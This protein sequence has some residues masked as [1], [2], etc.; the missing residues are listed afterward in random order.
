MNIVIGVTGSIAAYKTV[1]LVNLLHKQGHCVRVV[2][3][4]NATKFVQPLT[5]EAISHEAVITDMFNGDC[6]AL[7]HIN[8]A[9]WAD[10][11]MIA[12]ADANVIA[13]LAHGFA[14]D[15]LSTFI[16]AFDGPVLV[17]PAMNTIMYHQEVTQNNIALLKN[18]GY[19]IIS[20]TYG[21]LACGDIGD[22]KLADINTL[23]FCIEKSL[24][25]QTL[26]DFHLIVTAGPTIGPIDPVR[27][28]TNHSSGK[29]GFSIAREAVLRGAQVTLIA[30]VVQRETPFG[31]SRIDV[32]TTEEMLS[33]IENLL[34]SAD[35][36]VMAAAP[37]DFTPEE[38][39]HEK[40]KK[41][42]NEL[43]ITFRKNPDILKSLNFLLEGK[44]VVGFAAESHQL[45]QNAEKKLI[46]KKLDFIVANNIAGKDT[47]F[48][49][50]YNAATILFKDGH[51]K[52]ISKQLKTQLADKILDEIELIRQKKEER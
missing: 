3:T 47:A 29:M 49:S 33:A 35:G 10:V 8:L 25:S 13:K 2:M 1:D 21:K 36:L 18:N 27:F 34:P 43:S 42:G 6:V 16:L 20:P 46:E 44:I 39:H 37:A 32:S 45:L 12:P 52:V 31:V 30:G 24:T 19:E 40:I 9:K 7:E 51:Q 5:F 50:D 41:V 38:Y 48:Q 28:I 17:A 26:S 11:C 14:D 4:K 22:G 15:F 23:Q